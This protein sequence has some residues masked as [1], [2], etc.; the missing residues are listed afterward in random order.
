MIISVIIVNY[1][2]DQ[3]IT[4]LTSSLKHPNLEFL[5]VDNSSTFLSSS[6]QERTRVLHPRQN[7]GFGKAVNFAAQQSLGE[8]L[9]LLNPDVSIELTSILD[10]ASLLVSDGKLGI[11]APLINEKQHRGPFLNGGYWPTLPKMLMHVS[12]GARYSHKYRIFRGLYGHQRL[13]LA[14]EFIELDWVSGA[15]LAIRRRDFEEIGGFNER[16]FMYCEDME[17]SFRIGNL[18]KRVGIFPQSTGQHLGGSS[19]GREENLSVVN[20]LWLTNLVQFYKT[21]FSRNSSIRLFLW[22]QICTIGYGLR[23]IYSIL[24]VPRNS[25]SKIRIKSE[26]KRYFAYVRALQRCL[27]NEIK[28]LLLKV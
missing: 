15:C 25:N 17:L 16:W 2:S 13:K 27:G 28:I 23:W 10:M 21:F 7:L 6:T 14:E 26:S 18:G 20:T 19:D 5:I 3:M 22:I 4:N 11:V 12:L 8:V 1:F 24:R 9:V